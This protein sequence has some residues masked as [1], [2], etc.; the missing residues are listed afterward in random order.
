MWDVFISI[1]F[2]HLSRWESVPGLCLWYHAKYLLQAAHG[3]FGAWNQWATLSFGE[4]RRSPVNAAIFFLVSIEILLTK[5]FPFHHIFISFYSSSVQF[6]SFGLFFFFVVGFL[7]TL[8]R[9]P[10]HGVGG[11]QLALCLWGGH[12]DDRLFA[13]RLLAEPTQSLR[14]PGHRARGLLDNRPFYMDGA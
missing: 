4:F 2:F 3:V 1:I 14:T 12:E 7:E 5:S 11:F 13:A 6:S 8:H 9:L 10:H